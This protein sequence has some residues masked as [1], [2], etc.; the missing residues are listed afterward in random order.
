LIGLFGLNSRH[1][2][3]TFRRGKNSDEGNKIGIIMIMSVCLP[4]RMIQLEN[5]W[6][7]LYEIWY[8]LYSTGT[9]LKSNF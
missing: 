5:L 8:G 7:D 9:T 3:F 6:T 2:I 4:V 1:R